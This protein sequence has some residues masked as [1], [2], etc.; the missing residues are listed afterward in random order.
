MSLVVATATATAI[1]AASAAA[2]VGT[3]FTYLYFVHRSD[4]NAARDEAM[5]LAETRG[6]VIV[7]LR[8]RLAAL[9]RQHRDTTR[10]FETRV[11][12]LETALQTTVEEAREQAYRI[13]RF[14]AAALAD[15]FGGV[16]ADLEQDPPNVPS[17][18][19][20]VR[21]LLDGERPAA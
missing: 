2:A 15:I 21:Q 7:D 5:A 13:Q 9:E 11:R 12:E 3:F 6:E 19:E 18:L 20:R 4:A 10:A 8:R 16:Q 1:A 14:Y 17:A